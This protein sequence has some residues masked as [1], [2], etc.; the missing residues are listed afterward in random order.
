MAT[1]RIPESYPEFDNYSRSGNRKGI[2]NIKELV[3]FALQKKKPS[4]GRII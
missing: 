4:Q 1:K 3:E 2:D